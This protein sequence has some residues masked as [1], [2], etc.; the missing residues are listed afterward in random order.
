MKS[1]NAKKKESLAIHGGT[2]VRA[3][4]LP[5]GRQEITDADIK[6]VTDCLKSDWL[7]T[8]P[9][10]AEFEK[11]FAKKT[12]AREAVTFSNG[13]A[14]LH[15]IMYAIDVK[16]G[17]EVILPAMTFAAS[18][19]A[20]LYT[21]GKPIF[22]DCEPGTLLLDP[23]DAARKITKKTKAILAV[24]F[25]GQPCDYLELRELAT[26]RKIK[27]LTDACHALGAQAN[28]RSA[29]ALAD[30]TA[31]S[32]HPV[33]HIT[34][35]EGGM[36][37]G[38]EDSAMKR[39]RLF[40]NHGISTEFRER[41]EK[42]QT[43]YEMID[44]GFNY[45]LSDLQCAL[46]ISQ[47]SRLD[48][49]VAKRNELAGVYDE[50]LR[51][52]TGVSP[53]E[54]RSGVTHAFHLY[55]VRLDLAQWTVSRDELIQALR[56]EGIGANVHYAPVYFHPYYQKLGY[57][58]GSCPASEIAYAELVTLPLFPAMTATDVHDVVAAVKKLSGV[59]RK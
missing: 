43:A 29:G 11:A 27:L 54:R 13:T 30:L 4:L 16:P 41:H 21:G 28:N 42:G 7:T 57:K 55:V 20:V 31:F 46:G 3:T 1:V 37:T 40:R 10:V 36:V 2:P 12:G 48:A 35:A 59:Y 58:K 32:F 56:A 44:L 23:V 6:A 26:E 9:K 49:N 53:L 51:D 39:L 18:A 52:F 50:A 38:F 47:L 25:A 22:A 14:A 45:R 19:N 17:D 8:G 33:K 24:D 34:T 15:A 5:Y